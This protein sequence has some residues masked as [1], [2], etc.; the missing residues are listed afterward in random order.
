[1]HAL[2]EREILSYLV[3]THTHTYTHTHTHTHTHFLSLAALLSH[4][5]R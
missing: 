1:M 5:Y 4:G 2:K 3:L